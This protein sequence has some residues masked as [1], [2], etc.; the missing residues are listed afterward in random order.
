MNIYIYIKSNNHVS[1]VY[2]MLGFN[3][4][5]IVLDNSIIFSFFFAWSACLCS[6]VENIFFT[7]FRRKYKCS[8]LSKVD[9]ECCLLLSSKR[10]R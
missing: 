1:V 6:A 4:T 9:K 5:G 3:P 8:A 7:F 2:Q 10:K